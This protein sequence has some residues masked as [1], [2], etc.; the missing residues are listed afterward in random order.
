MSR[1]YKKTF[2]SFSSNVFLHK[3]KQHFY[4]DKPATF[5]YHRIILSNFTF[6]YILIS[7]LKLTADLTTSGPIG[8]KQLYCRHQMSS[9][10]LVDILKTLFV[11]S[12]FSYGTPYWKGIWGTTITKTTTA[13]T[14]KHLSF[15]V[16]NLFLQENV[17]GLYISKDRFTRVT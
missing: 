5:V 7:I 6:Y 17:L 2:N 9:F 12:S 10:P 4:Y 16:K 3:I 11:A 14:F 8:N 15:W 13:I 1:W